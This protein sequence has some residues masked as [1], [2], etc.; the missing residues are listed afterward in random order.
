M[1]AGIVEAIGDQIVHALPAH[2]GEIHR[3]AGFVL[4]LGHLCSSEMAGGGYAVSRERPAAWWQVQREEV[5]PRRSVSPAF[6]LS[7]GLAPPRP[8]IL[9][10]GRISLSLPEYGPAGSGLVSGRRTEQ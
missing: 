5:L 8:D 6:A 4:A 7:Q 10:H 2:I 3:R 9:T 1:P